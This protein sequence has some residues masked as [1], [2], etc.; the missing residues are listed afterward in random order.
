MLAIFVLSAEEYLY[1]YIN[2]SGGRTSSGEGTSVE[3]VH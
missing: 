2:S 1:D 3:M